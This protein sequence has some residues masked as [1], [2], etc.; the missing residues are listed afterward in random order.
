MLGMTLED[1]A[2]V[3]GVNKTTVQRYESGAIPN[4]PI[5]TL[6]ELSRLYNVSTNDILDVQSSKTQN[7]LFIEFI[8][9]LDFKC[10]HLNSEKTSTAI[11]SENQSSALIRIQT[12]YGDDYEVTEDDLINLKASLQD[13]L[14]FQLF[15]LNKIK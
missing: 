15:K 7:D 13:Y 6:K 1:V 11:F 3:I 14:S 10:I 5:E 8:E 12:P 9:T 4:I 2:S